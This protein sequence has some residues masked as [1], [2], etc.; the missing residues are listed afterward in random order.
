MSGS[1]NGTVPSV[2]RALQNNQCDITQIRTQCREGLAEPLALLQTLNSRLLL[3]YREFKVRCGAL[4]RVLQHAHNVLCW[5]LAHFPDGYSSK[6]GASL[7]DSGS[8]AIE[9]CCE[10]GCPSLA[11]R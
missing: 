2:T 9:R 7:S 1:T 8:S 6:R 4:N 3:P 11:I 5:Y 10:Y